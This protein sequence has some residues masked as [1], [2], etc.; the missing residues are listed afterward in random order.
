MYFCRPW[1]SNMVSFRCVSVALNF[2]HD[3]FSIK[4]FTR[5]HLWDLFTISFTIFLLIRNITRLMLDTEVKVFHESISYFM[6]WPWN[7]ISWN[8]LKEKF[9]SVSFP[10]EFECIRS[11][12]TLSQG[13]V[14]ALRQR[15]KIRFASAC[16]VIFFILVER[17]FE[18]SSC[19]RLKC[20]NVSQYFPRY[21]N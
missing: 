18:T 7:C 21:F 2:L 5:Y 4:F 9:H 20:N 3:I 13:N 11:F 8:A 15:Y 1:F 16:A 17:R 12:V 19:T 10:K 6:K 14:N